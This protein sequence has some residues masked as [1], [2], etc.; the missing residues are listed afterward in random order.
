MQLEIQ[1]LSFGGLSK[2]VLIDVFKDGRASSKL[3]EHTFALELGLIQVSGDKSYDL[4]STSGKKYEVK[5]F[6]KYGANFSPSMH[7]GDKGLAKKIRQE[8]GEVA[9]NEHIELK[10]QELLHR[11]SDLIYIIY[12]IINFPTVRFELIEGKELVSKYPKGKISYSKR[13]EI[14]GE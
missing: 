5:A 4:I 10:Q 3:M 13:G 11:A 8:L 12:D 14:F 6:T 7:L 9:Y 2:E 1:N